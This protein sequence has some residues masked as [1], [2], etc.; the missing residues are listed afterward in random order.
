M[1]SPHGLSL[2]KFEWDT[3]S[4]ASTPE[5]DDDQPIQLEEEA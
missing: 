5:Y 4:S 2:V 3:C 1:G